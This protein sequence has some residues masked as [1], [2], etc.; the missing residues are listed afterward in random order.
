MMLLMTC[1]FEGI[2]WFDSVIN[3]VE[4]I[5]AI[6]NLILLI[7]FTNRE[8]AYAKS[9]ESQ[10]ELD[11]VE[12][13]KLERQKLWYDKIVIERIIEY[14]LEYFD[15]SDKDFS[16]KKVHEEAEK[17]ALL[18]KIKKTNRQ[19]KHIVIPCLEIFSHDLAKAIN[20]MLQE[21]CDILAA[22][23]E[24]NGIIYHPY[25]ERDVNNKKGE[26]LKKIYEFD[27]NHNLKC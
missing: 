17:K 3:V 15:S 12:M 22:E 6:G 18:E 24:W 2:N 21:Y 23:V 20:H 5:C 9:K 27:F 1:S 8:W 13:A 7:Y 26:I 10:K 19:Y 11:A 25:F 4:A 16:G 14:L